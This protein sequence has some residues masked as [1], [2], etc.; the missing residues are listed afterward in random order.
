[1]TNGSVTNEIAS[2]RDELDQPSLSARAFE[3]FTRQLFVESGLKPGM[4][5][6]DVFSG[7][8]DVALLAREFVGQDGLVTGFD[9]SSGPVAYANER[10][11]FRG[12]KN[13][14]FLEGQIDDL[15]FGADF[16][17]IVGRVVLAY[18]RDPVRDLRALARCLRPGG[19][20]V[21]QEI[22]HLAARTIPPAAVVDQ[23]REWIIEAFERVGIELQMGSKLYPTFSEAGLQP[24]RMRLDGFI[25]GAESM[26][27]MFLTNVV[28]MLLPQLET[29][30]VAT[31]EDVQID[32][33]EERL[34]LD[35][36]SIGGVMQSPLLIG[37]WTRMSA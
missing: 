16:D 36:A 12:L 33:L 18:R 4:R 13:V 17:A 23:V 22:D 32:T 28:R 15:P 34:R 14:D 35:L 29:L 8:G 31:A 37:A 21:F 1:M 6:L 2:S 24:P 7:A 9:Q 20:L 27:P 26:A 19:L 11:A 25:G 5:V 30:G 3:P 10:A